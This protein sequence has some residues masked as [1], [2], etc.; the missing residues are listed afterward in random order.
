VVAALALNRRFQRRNPGKRPYRW[1]YYLSIASVLGGVAL[2]VFLEAGA[3]AAIVCAAVYAALAWSFARRRRWAW[4]AL[5]VL[6]FNPAA[7]VINLV[8]LRKRWAEDSVPAGA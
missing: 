6:T 7:W 4:I 1:G 5:T 3:A 8:Y 2:G